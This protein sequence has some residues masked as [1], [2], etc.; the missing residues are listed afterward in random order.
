M[1][2]DIFPSP[3]LLDNADD[4]SVAI[5]DLKLTADIHSTYG[6]YC[7]GSPQDLDLIQ[8]KMYHYGIRNMDFELNPHLENRITDSLK[9]LIDDNRVLFLLWIFNYKKEKPED[10]FIIIRWDKAKE[11]ELNHSIRQTIATMDYYDEMGWPA[12]PKYKYCKNC[13]VLECMERVNI[14]SL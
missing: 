6:D 5:I 4:L 13:P 9:R 8:G 11:A 7:Y 12:N 3:V 1:E 14:E 10:K 2:L